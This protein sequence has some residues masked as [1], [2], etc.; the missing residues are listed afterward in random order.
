MGP[1]IR[2][3]KR[4]SIIAVVGSGLISALLFW[5]DI[6]PVICPLFRDTNRCILI[7]AA[8]KE[9]AAKLDAAKLDGGLVLE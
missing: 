5:G 8:V 1:R 7:S 9:A 6:Y 4:K 3:H 2:K